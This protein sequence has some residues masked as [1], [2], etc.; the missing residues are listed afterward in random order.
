M[1]ARMFLAAFALLL[2]AG[3][4]QADD[5]S[6]FYVG[7]DERDGSFDSQSIVPKEDG[8]YRIVVKASAFAMCDT[9]HP[10]AV[11]KATGRILE[12][13][14]VRQETV[15]HCGNGAEVKVDDT[16]YTL[17]Q[18]TGTLS[19]RAHVGDDIL[20]YHRVSSGPNDAWA[21]I[22]AGVDAYDGSLDWMS[23]V[24]NGDGTYR[25]KVKSNSFGF[26]DTTDPQAIMTGT[27]RIV[28]GK[29][30]RQNTVATCS[31]GDKKPLDDRT[32]TLDPTTGIVSLSAN[33]TDRT[34]YYH[35]LAK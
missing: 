19:Y 11:L 13:K 26:C 25:I 18:E 24:P 15:A 8:T 6:G 28:D 20:S 33:S 16:V 30:V 14:F 27:G 32:Y 9:T 17:D 7:I 5:W 2:A 34:L 35:Q 23:I 31:D 10:D 21:G 3:L 12:D 29:L 4:A 22:F 1:I